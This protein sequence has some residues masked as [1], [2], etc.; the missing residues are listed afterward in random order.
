[1]EE[2]YE[3][4][5]AELRP[6]PDSDEEID[7]LYNAFVNPE[8]TREQRVKAQDEWLEYVATYY[9]I[10]LEPVWDWSGEK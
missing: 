9:E 6:D 8:L 10:E 7:M 1:M 4:L 2:L 3:W 5:P